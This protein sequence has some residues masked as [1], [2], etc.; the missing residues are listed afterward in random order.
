LLIKF[1]QTLHQVELNYDQQV[2]R[3]VVDHLDFVDLIQIQFDEMVEVLVEV[4]DELM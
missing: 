3:L 2:H 1:K 4:L